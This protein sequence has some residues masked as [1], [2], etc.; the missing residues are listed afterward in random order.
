V[1]PTAA[2]FWIA[3]TPPYTNEHL[4]ELRRHAGRTTHFREQVIGRTPGGRDLLLW[5]ISDAKAAAGSKQT[6]WLMFRQHAWESGSSWVGDALVRALLA[7]TEEA[8]RWRERI[9]WKIF[10]L[11]DPDGVARGGVRF[12][13]K[14]YDLNR[15]WDAIDAKVMPE[16]AAQHAAVAAWLRAGNRIDLFLSLHN[17]E[18]AEYLQGPPGDGGRDIGPQFFAALQERTTFEPSRPF[19]GSGATTTEGVKGRM[20]VVQGL[21]RDFQIPAFLMEQ[22]IAKSPRTGRLPGIAERVTF[23][24]QLPAAIAAVF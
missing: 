11:C 17:T 24:R 2:R 18:T 8:R 5:T 16:I 7:D 21:W 4:A 12:N 15:N 20:T 6:V 14:G 10:P 1:R 13:G 22:R 3:H 9:V 19:F 23:G